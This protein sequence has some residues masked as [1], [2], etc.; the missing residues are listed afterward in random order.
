MFL[1]A[2]FC[3]FIMPGMIRRDDEGKNYFTIYLNEAKIGATDSRDTIDEVM[4]K[5]RRMISGD[6]TELIY[7]R[8]DLEVEGK[9]VLFGVI[10]SEKTLLNRVAGVLQENSIQTLQ[11]AYTVKVNEYSVNL[12][13]SE[14]VESLLNA[15]LDKYDAKEEYNVELVLDPTRELHVLTARVNKKVEQEEEEKEVFWESV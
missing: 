3:G 6:S 11:R 15:A 9:K 12:A 7:A 10:D 2:V 8:M 5:A 13:T 14:E 4:A 1:V